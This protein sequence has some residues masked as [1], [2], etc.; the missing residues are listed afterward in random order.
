MF[1]KKK[2]KLEDYENCLEATQLE[3]KI[4]HLE[5]DEIDINSLKKNLKELIKNNKL[6]LKTQ[7]GFKGERHSIF[8]EDTNKI[9]LSLNDDKRM[10][11]IDLMETYAS[12]TSI[13]LV[14]DK[15]RL[16]VTI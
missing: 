1:H 8:T 16:N 4:N 9:V 2:L 7:K 15:K 3:N 6:I 13:D 5:K 12:G 14:S 10:Q 11:S